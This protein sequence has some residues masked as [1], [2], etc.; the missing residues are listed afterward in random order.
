MDI[1]SNWK[2]T[3]MPIFLRGG[4]WLHAGGHVH[5]A[6]GSLSVDLSDAFPKLK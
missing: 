4:R 2:P 5:L 3:L 1:N 6:Q